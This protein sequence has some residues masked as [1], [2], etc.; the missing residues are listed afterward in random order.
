MLA[1]RV[2]RTRRPFR[3]GEWWEGPPGVLEPHTSLRHLAFARDPELRVVPAPNGDVLF[4]VA[5][6]IDAATV[7]AMKGD[8][9]AH[10]GDATLDALAASRPLLV[11]E[12][13]APRP[14]P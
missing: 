11:T 5:V 3:A 12:L 10:R 8:E 2:H 14:G 13:P 6:G 4:L 9:L 1:R 7:E